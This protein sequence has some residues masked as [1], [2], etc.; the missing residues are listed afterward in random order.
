[1]WWYTSSRFSII[2][3]DACD[4]ITINLNTYNKILKSNIRMAKQNH[5]YTLFE[6]YKFNIKNTW[7]NIKDLLHQFKVKID[8]PN[9]FMINGE[10]LTD[11]NIIA[12]TFC[13]Y[14]TDIGP[15]LTKNIKMPQNINGK[16][17]LTG[18]HN[19]KFQC[20]KIDNILILRI[21]NDLPYESST[22]FDDVSM[23]LIKAIKTEIVPALTCTFKESSFKTRMPGTV[24]GQQ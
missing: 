6:K 16:D 11:S 17:F 21:I 8:F 10:E 22:C 3:T 14:F 24:V 1:M 7:T 19:C 18:T 15:S 12:N 13:K 20:K 9:N 2:D 5:Y 4:R 23:R